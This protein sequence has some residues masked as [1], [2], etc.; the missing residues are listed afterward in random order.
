M[1]FP[2]DLRWKVAIVLFELFYIVSI[3]FVLWGNNEK[4]E[5]G[6]SN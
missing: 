2:G 3:F 1:N 4:C 6:E 5:I